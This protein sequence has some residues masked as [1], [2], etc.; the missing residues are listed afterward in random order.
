MLGQ[1]AA[2]APASQIELVGA[3]CIDAALS[4]M[5]LHCQPVGQGTASAD[6]SSAAGDE[7]FLEKDGI[8]G[9]GAAEQR[10]SISVGACSLLRALAS[11]RQ[12]AELV[13]R[14]LQIVSAV[15]KAFQAGGRNARLAEDAVAVI[16]AFAESES[17]ELVAAAQGFELVKAALD[18]HA[19][20]PVIAWLG[21][22][23][24]ASLT[25]GNRGNAQIFGNAKWAA[26]AAAALDTHG[27][28]DEN[29]ARAACRCVPRPAGLGR[30]STLSH[31]SV[32]LQGSAQPFEGGRPA[33]GAR[34][35]RELR[36]GGEGGAREA[37][38]EGGQ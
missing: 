37:Q 33:A 22:S 16:A 26:T 10:L 23:V 30:S 12:I 28:T 19:P 35:R 3:G 13:T 29:C 34:A 15:V 5:D 1:L 31:G 11:N 20:S 24:V 14:E 18:L 9:R 21:C 7:E 27:A 25:D 36:S 4:I 32:M 8:V 38:S 6:A 17:R 2:R